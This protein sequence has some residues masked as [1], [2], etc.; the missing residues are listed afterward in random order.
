[1][2][3][4]KTLT[5]DEFIRAY[6]EEGP[7]EYIDGER[8]PVSPTLTGHGLIARTL[9]LALYNYGVPKNLGEPFM[10]LPFVMVETSDWVTGSRVP[11]V[12]FFKA[13]R[14]AAYKANNADWRDKPFIL[15]PDVVVEI[16]SPNDRYGDVYE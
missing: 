13:E 6:D 3:I 12:M 5:L 8:M 16:I 1:M 4:A 14:L 9:L 11:D 7:F 2:Q 10:E 15:V